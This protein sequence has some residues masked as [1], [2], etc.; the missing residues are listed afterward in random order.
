MTGSTD[1][2]TLKALDIFQAPPTECGIASINYID[3][4]PVAAITSDSILEFNIPGSGENYIDLK[5][6]YLHIKAKITRTN[7]ASLLPDDDVT[8]CNL[9]AHSLWSQV[10]IMC[11]NR[12][13]Y[14]SGVHY[15][16]KAMIETLFNARTHNGS[17]LECEMFYKDTGGHMDDISLKGKNKGLIQRH[18]R[19]AGSKIVDMMAPIYAD[20]CQVDRLM[21]N[22]VDISIK[23]YPSKPEFQLTSAASYA[24]IFKVEIVS[25]VFKACKVTVNKDVV[26]AQASVLAKEIPAVF[27]I[28]RTE[29]R[30][31]VIPKGQ[32]SFHQSDIFQNK[33]PSYMVIAFVAS[34]AFQGDFKRNG[35]S[36]QDFDLNHIGLYKN[37][38]CVPHK[39]VIVDFNSGEYTEAYRTLFKDNINQTDISL[40]EYANGYTFFVYRL[41]D[42]TYSESCIPPTERGNLSLEGSFR[43]GLPENVNILIYANFPG[44]IQI[45]QFRSITL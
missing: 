39:P 21:L 7:G 9:W 3:Y 2:V 34:K 40:D 38:Q 27:P 24:S 15:G 41:A 6:S 45:D 42:E 13:I 18:A 44:L 33:I 19:V 16:Y 25:A 37:S 22:G 5:R 11:N 31:F 36:F 30:S 10:D 1:A 17:N 43:T 23:L 4:R 20:L 12:L 32:L 8:P 26:A 14:N 35:Y 29:I 28:R